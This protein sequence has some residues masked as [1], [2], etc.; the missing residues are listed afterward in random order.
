MQTIK[1]DRYGTIISKKLLP[2]RSLQ[3]QNIV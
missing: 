3:N 1:Q 2:E